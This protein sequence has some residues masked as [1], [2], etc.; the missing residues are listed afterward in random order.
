[1]AIGT[2]R[3]YLL[4]KRNN[5]IAA[6]LHVIDK[7]DVTQEEIDKGK[8][9]TLQKAIDY[10]PNSLHDALVSW[11]TYSYETKPSTILIHNGE[12]TEEIENLNYTRIRG[13]LTQD[14]GYDEL[15]SV[16]EKAREIAK[17]ARISEGMEPEEF[18]A[19]YLS[20]KN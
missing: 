17:D 10:R 8:V 14:L 16:I 20:R 6:L 4:A 9:L 12:I 5:I 11:V 7:S 13:E 18:K 19:V 3:T 1:M 15:L 2:V